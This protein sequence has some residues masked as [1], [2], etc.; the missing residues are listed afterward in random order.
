MADTYRYWEVYRHERYFD[1]YVKPPISA[2][3]NPIYVTTNGLGPSDPKMMNE[4]PINDV[5]TKF[6]SY[7]DRHRKPHE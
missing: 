7:L 4:L 3:W 5:W 6:Y 2:K 1:S